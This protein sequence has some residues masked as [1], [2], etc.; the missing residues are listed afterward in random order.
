MMDT[1]NSSNPT[2]NVGI[3]THEDV[4]GGAANHAPVF[5]FTSIRGQAELKNAL[6]L[7]AVDPGIGGVLAFGDR[8]TGK[9]TTVR[10]LGALLAAGGIQAPVVDVPL[11]VTEDRLIGALDIDVALQ[12]GRSQLRPGLLAEAHGGFLYIDEINLLDDHLVDVLLDVAASGKNIVER[13]G[14]SHV[15]DARF[16]LVGSGNPEEGD[17]RPQLQDR[18]GLALWVH[19][20]EDVAQRLAVVRDRLAFDEDPEGFVS[21]VTEQQRALAQEVVAARANLTAVELSDDML[22]RIIELC[23]RS[24]CVGH[25]GEVVLTRAAR[26]HAA[27][28]GRNAVSAVDV[29]AVAPA[30]LRHR[31]QSDAFETPVDIDARLHGL[32]QEICGA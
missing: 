24:Q 20:L 10:A 9:T 14:I 28:A 1:A 26:A 21:N 22:L 27:L 2:E 32:I 13:D 18:F 3:T 23:T 6:L 8:G 17:L 4:A 19:T 12:E 15:H 11:G 7:T 30:C 16:V 29:A 5:P 31:I 25:R